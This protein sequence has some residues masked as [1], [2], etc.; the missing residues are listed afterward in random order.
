MIQIG[1]GGEDFNI[2]PVTQLEPNPKRLMDDLL[3]HYPRS[4]LTITCSL[5][6]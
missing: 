6:W 5:D 3:S 1:H 2:Q 4:I